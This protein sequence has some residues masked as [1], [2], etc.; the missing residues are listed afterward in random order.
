MLRYFRRIEER[1]QE[2]GNHRRKYMYAIEEHGRLLIDRLEE[3]GLFDRSS[4]E[5][6]ITQGKP[7]IYTSAREIVE[8]IL[9]SPLKYPLPDESVG[10]LDE[11][12]RKIEGAHR[13]KQ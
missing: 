13:D 1:T 9:S 12:I 8:K 3:S 6:W 10:K 2:L 4:Y 7:G 5:T 11:I